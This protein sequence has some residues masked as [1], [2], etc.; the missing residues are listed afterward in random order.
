MILYLTNA[1]TEILALRSIVEGLPEGFPPLRAAN[2]AAL[3]AL[4][5][6]ADV[7]VV[8]VRLLGG[9]SAVARSLRANCSAACADSAVPLLAFGG[10]GGPRR[11]DDRSVHRA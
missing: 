8:M 5:D 4:P 1:P 2:P 6:L 11:G 7:D 3:D 9:A 10:R